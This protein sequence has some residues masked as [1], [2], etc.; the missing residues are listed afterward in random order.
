MLI[1]VQNDARQDRFLVEA[2]YVNWIDRE[3]DDDFIVMEV[4]VISTQ[5]KKAGTTALAF[6]G[7]E[8]DPSLRLRIHH[9]DRVFIMNADGKTVDSKRIVVGTAARQVERED[10]AFA[11]HRASETNKGD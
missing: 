9:G 8:A 10:P 3:P 7:I 4:H 5:T 1:R 11:K 6:T 2:A